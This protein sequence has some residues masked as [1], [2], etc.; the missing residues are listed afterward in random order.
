[1]KEKENIFDEKLN[2]YEQILVQFHEDIGKSKRVNEKFIIIGTYLFLHDKLT[3]TDLVNLTGFSSGTIST[4]LSVMEG[5][6]FISK[7]RIPK[8]HTFEYSITIPINQLLT[9]RYDTALKSI[10]SIEAF[11]NKKIEELEPLIQKSKT[12][13][14]H[15]SKR[16][17]QLIN[18]LEYYKEV[19]SILE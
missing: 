1:M 3:Q 13:A 9:D 8:T 19:Y 2:K 5:M 12:G 18:A 11:L 17:Q 14:E 16:I 7:Q 15:L 6:G 10:I 4:Y